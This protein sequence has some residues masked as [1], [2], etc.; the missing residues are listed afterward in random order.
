MVIAYVV[1]S[2]IRRSRDARD[3]SGARGEK[4]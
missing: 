4:R 1:V 2:G 3:D